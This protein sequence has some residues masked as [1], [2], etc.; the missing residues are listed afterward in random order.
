MEKKREMGRGQG[1]D[2]LS[3]GSPFRLPVSPVLL[4]GDVPVRTALNA[5]CLD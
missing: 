5:E 4:F 2:S 1:N 3:H